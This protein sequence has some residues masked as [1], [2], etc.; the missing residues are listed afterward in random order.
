MYSRVVYLCV[1]CVLGQEY[2]GVYVYGGTEVVIKSK[3]NQLLLTSSNG[4]AVTSAI[5]A[6]KAPLRFQV[7]IVQMTIL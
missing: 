7:I 3:D 2:E 5:L 1:S 4:A 6:Y